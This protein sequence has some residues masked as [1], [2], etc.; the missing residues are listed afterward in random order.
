MEGCAIVV[1]RILAESVGVREAGRSSSSAAERGSLS[2][3]FREHSRVAWPIVGCKDVD[4]VGTGRCELIVDHPGRGEKGR[5]TTDW[6]TT[7]LHGKDV[8][9]DVGMEW[10]LVE[11]IVSLLHRTRRLFIVA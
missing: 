9:D 6:R 2:V 4:E 8:A 1:R 7:T 10:L 5:S 3:G 11:R